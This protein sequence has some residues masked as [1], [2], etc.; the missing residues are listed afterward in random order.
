MATTETLKQTITKQEPT[1]DLRT[2]IERSAKELARAVPGHL[3]ADRMVRIALTCIR[4][5]PELAR[6][7]PESFLGALFVA[8]Q[9]GIEPVGGR[10]YILPFWN[11]RKK[12]DGTWHKVL[13]AQFV[14]GY[15][16]VA[17]QFYR[18]EKSIM[19]SWGVVH[20]KDEF[21]YEYGTNA[22]L[23]HIPAIGDRGEVLAYWVMANLTNGGKPFIVMTASDC[24]EHGRKHSKTYD[25]KTKQFYDSSPWVTS[26]ESMCL[27]TC[28]IQL[29]KLL[30]MSVE[31]QRAIAA[32][33]SSR[34]YRKGVEDA[35]DLPD[36]T[37][38]KEVES[39]SKEVQKEPEIG[40]GEE[41]GA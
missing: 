4:T 8:A 13:E 14:L 36:T 3:K 6:C 5:T 7:T 11:S 40:F 22:F 32:D 37:N 17:E 24:M 20:A 41:K 33:E 1:Q 28:F 16:G 19:L 30:P 39:E 38:W 2:L 18:H 12:P 10:A 29:A 31:L 26:P 34:E 23:K 15:K 35:L 21:S 27:K 25:K 9:L